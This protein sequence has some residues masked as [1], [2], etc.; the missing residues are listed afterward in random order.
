MLD[1]RN[2]TRLPCSHVLES[3]A[4]NVLNASRIVYDFYYKPITR[5]MR[6]KT[7]AVERL[8]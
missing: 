3:C 4:E 5:K 1:I 2:K 7:F 8:D 6:A